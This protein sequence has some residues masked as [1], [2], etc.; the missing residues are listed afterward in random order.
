MLCKVNIT[1]NFKCN[2]FKSNIESIRLYVRP[3]VK[4]KNHNLFSLAK[5]QANKAVRLRQQ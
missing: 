1:D 5:I 3:T 2:N 4:I